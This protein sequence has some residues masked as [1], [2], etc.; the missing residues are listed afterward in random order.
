VSA[1][2]LFALAVAGAVLV[3]LTCTL[4]WPDRF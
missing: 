2:S 4:I 3:Y 1:E